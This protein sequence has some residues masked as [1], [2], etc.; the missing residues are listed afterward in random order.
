MTPAG[1]PTRDRVTAGAKP[2]L[3]PGVQIVP[4]KPGIATT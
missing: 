4:V 1:Q 3:P 2:T